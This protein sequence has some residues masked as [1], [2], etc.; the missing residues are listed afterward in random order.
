MLGREGRSGR[1][2]LPDLRDQ[3]CWSES[4]VFVNVKKPY[5]FGRLVSEG[6]D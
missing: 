3:S 1:C 4:R 6:R 5:D 2:G